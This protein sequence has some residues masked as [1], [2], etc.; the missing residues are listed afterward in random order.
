MIQTLKKSFL[1][2]ILLNMLFFSSAMA[3]ST[4][5][6]QGK[7]ID[8]FLGTPLEDVKVTVTIEKKDTPI[9]LLTDKSGDFKFSIES[10]STI[11]LIFE[12]NHF[13]VFSKALKNVTQSTTIDNIKMEATIETNEEDLIPVVNLN[14]T[15]DTDDESN[16]S[17]VLTSSRD[18]FLNT[19]AF[20]FGS[21]RFRIRGY[22]YR[23]STVYFNGVPVNDIERGGVSWSSWGGLN[24]VMRNR[25]V[26]LGLAPTEFGYGGIGLNTTIDTR[27]ISQRKQLRASYAISNRS[28]RNRA[29]ITYSTGPLKGGWAVS[30]SG[31][32]RWANKGF[33]EGT[34]YD[35]YSYF[36]S[37]DKKIGNSQSL[38]MTIFGSPRDRGKQGAAT[39]E[40]Y[41]LAGTNYYNS[42]W[43]Y[44]NGKVRNSRVSH[45]H[46][47]TAILR[48]D[49]KISDK[50]NLITAISF[51][52]GSNGATALDWYEAP[53]PRPDYYRY[54]P[55]YATDEQAAA[56]EAVLRKDPTLLQIKWEKLYAANRGSYA[57]IENAN[58]VAGNTVSGKRALYVVEDRRYDPTRL[59]AATT[60]E[61]YL[62]KKLILTAGLTYQK[63]ET[64]NFKVMEDLLGGDFYVD[65]DKF[66]AFNAGGDTDFIQNDLDTPNKIIKEGDRFGYDYVMHINRFN[67]W[68]QLQLKLN[69][70]NFFAAGN[71]G[72]TTFWREGMVRNGKF[73]DS[74][75]GVSDKPS[76]TEFGGKAGVTY[77]M[78]G[79][80]YLFVNGSIDNQAPLARHGFVSARTRNQT[81]DGL[82]TSLVQSVE[83]GYQMK[84]PKAKVKVIGY[85]TNI[86]D[87]ISSNSFYL[88]NAI[89]TSTG[90]SGGFVNYITKNIDVISTG[91]EIAGEVEVLPSL[92][93]KAVAAIGQTYYTNRPN[94]TVYLDEKAEQLRQTEVYIK[95]FN[96]SSGPKNAYNLGLNYSGKGHWFASLNFNYFDNNWLGFYP[97]R[98]TLEAVANT[99]DPQYDLDFIER[100][101]ELWNKIIDQ[102]KAPAGFTL[103][104]FCGKS[105]KIDWDNYIYVNVGINNILDKTDLVTGGYEQNRFDFRNKDVDR[106]PNR[107]YYGYGRNYYISVT[108]RMR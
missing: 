29:M 71:V 11:N 37:V 33:V 30:A 3:Q 62:S 56:V 22:D 86:F 73:P 45:A 47:P 61:A 72:S 88:D 63:H 38:N 9:S 4:V 6:V 103:D 55:S 20:A 82:E 36:L 97:E 65:I 44:Q 40:L 80:N 53:D 92:K 75:M 48:H 26:S 34:F 7:V 50:A 31:S 58:G 95:N 57:E 17:S 67:G 51:Q 78:N 42:Y 70:W 5:T 90:T 76:F 49:W 12:K 60:L 32:R 81:V 52:K 104:L 102:D 89:P 87:M 108:Y 18:P 66:A 46:L 2:G 98:R 21:A 77:K 16:I 100:G 13:A 96:L 85:F 84:A 8:R 101:S 59:N 68:A 107:Y 25:T 91:V 106:Y 28:Y 23:Y 64:H 105:F 79:R 10:G 74:S 35:A 15:D 54:L 1:L 69:K 93:L 43:G 99:S 83:G 39:K 14:E 19:A 27:A 41:D 24:D 94:V